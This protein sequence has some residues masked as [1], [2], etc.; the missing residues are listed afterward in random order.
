MNVS[1]GAA[2]W[3]REPSELGPL[4]AGLSKVL[5]GTAETLE[6][7]FRIESPGAGAFQS[8]R[9]VFG[10]VHLT[11]CTYGCGDFGT[12]PFAVQIP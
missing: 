11:D 1:G 12:M 8:G 4:L 6:A 10:Q 7:H 9:T 3:A 2:F 5:A